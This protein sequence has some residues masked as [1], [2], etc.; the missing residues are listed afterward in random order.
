[1]AGPR[2]DVVDVLAARRALEAAAEAGVVGEAL[3]VL[4][5]RAA[6]LAVV[7]FKDDDAARAA[8]LAMLIEV[9]LCRE[10][11]RARGAVVLLRNGEHF[12]SLVF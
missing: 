3:H 2:H 6:A 10:G 1:M 7:R 12:S 9:L 4:E 11:L 8:F 5:R